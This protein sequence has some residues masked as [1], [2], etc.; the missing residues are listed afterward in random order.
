MKYLRLIQNKRMKLHSPQRWG[1]Q[2]PNIMPLCH[3]SWD[4][5]FH[6]QVTENAADLEMRVRYFYEEFNDGYM[7]ISRHDFSF[8][9]KER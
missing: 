7:N 6:T 2:S 3:G 1:Y 5:Q 9:K 8:P 4:I